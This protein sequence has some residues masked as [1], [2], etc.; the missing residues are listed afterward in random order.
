MSE[1]DIT[2]KTMLHDLLEIDRQPEGI[3]T[4]RQLA[5][6]RGGLDDKGFIVLGRAVS[7]WSPKSV[8]DDL[9]KA[10]ALDPWAMMAKGWTQVANVRA[11]V[12]SSQGPP[13]TTASAALLK[14]DLDIKI[15]PR[16]VL[17]VGGVDWCDVDF[18]VKLMLAI[19]SAELEL[20][21]GALCA[22]KLGKVTGSINVSC[23]DTPIPAFKHDL[24]FRSEY[25]FDPPV[26]S[27]T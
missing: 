13:A 26:L 27:A 8:E 21:D 15:K 6:L 20:F 25:R 23:R 1:S 10:F 12:K 24:K 11:A 22:L 3:E 4:V 17:S 16:L 5:A 2:P 9:K 19:E 14:H 18:E 7:E